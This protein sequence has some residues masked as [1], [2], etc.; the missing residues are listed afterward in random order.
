MISGLMVCM[1]RA[2]G[3]GIGVS[4]RL[5]SYPLRWRVL[6]TDKLSAKLAVALARG[7]ATG[8]FPL[9]AGVYF[10]PLEIGVSFFPLEIG[11][12][13][14]LFLPPMLDSY[15]GPRCVKLL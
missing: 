6:M 10:F 13:F 2:I 15:V 7:E 5:G 4:S 8:F 1:V 14:F 9:E 3:K 12:F 11:V